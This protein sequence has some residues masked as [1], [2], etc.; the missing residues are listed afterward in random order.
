MLS[1]LILSH[2]ALLCTNSPLFCDSEL[3]ATI[4]IAWVYIIIL[5]ILLYTLIAFRNFL[6][7]FSVMLLC[8]NSDYKRDHNVELHVGIMVIS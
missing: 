4:V 7:L 6:L 8:I 2:A 5:R 1:H 3:I